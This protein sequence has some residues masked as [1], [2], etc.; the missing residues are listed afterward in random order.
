MSAITKFLPKRHLSRCVGQF[1]HWQGPHWWAR[2]SIRIF[3]WYYDINLSEAEKPYSAYSSIGD[4]FVRRLKQGVR[5]IGEG[6][7]LHPADSQITQAAAIT[8]GTLIQAKG[9]TY[10]LSDFTQDP[11]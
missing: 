9:L 3:A 4:F 1:I 8:E 6:W 7:A 2:I 5:V 11:E 10:R